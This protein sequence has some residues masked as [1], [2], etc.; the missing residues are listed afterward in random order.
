MNRTS[1]AALFAVPILMWVVFV[2][3]QGCT[4]E[5]AADAPQDTPRSWQSA[6]MQ[7]I[8]NE[9]R[10]L[11]RSYPREE[12][13]ESF[14]A[15]DVY[16]EIA[17]ARRRLLAGRLSNQDL[18]DLAAC[19][20][21]LP[22]RFYERQGGFSADILAIMIETFA[23]VGDR[24]ALVDVLSKRFVSS[25]G[26]SERIEYYLATRGS[27]AQDFRGSR[28][29]DPIMVLGEAYS[30]CETPE[31][32][33]EI[34]AAVRRGFR[35]L[36]I[37]GKDDA[38]YVANA[39]KWYEAEKDHLV[40]NHRYAQNEIRPLYEP[41]RAEDWKPSKPACGWQPLFEE[42]TSAWPGMDKIAAILVIWSVH[43]GI[44]AV[45]CAPIVFFGRKRV[46][47]QWWE[48]LAF[49]LP[50]GVWLLLTASPL[51]IGRKGIGNLVEPFYLA[52]G[53]PVAAMVRLGVGQRPSRKGR[54]LVITVL[55]GVLCIAAAAVFFIVPPLLSIY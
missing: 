36:G 35:G 19:L 34:A 53:V 38:E 49:V 18:H 32:R 25:V 30:R 4:G 33:A 54:V 11:S 41:E 39:M 43:F 23:E 48:L 47:W 9:Y 42:A 12:G 8:E 44:A 16:I 55:I 1:R 26:S 46:H 27:L 17:C 5:H 21:T 6:R 13:A 37:R 2:G 24:D 51:S 28:L 29:R 50:F 40:V 15:K 7:A 52:L 45:L 22:T 14:N 20:D 10:E 31:V 3:V